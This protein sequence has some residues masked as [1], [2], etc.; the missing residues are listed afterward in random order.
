MINKKSSLII[1]ARIAK[2]EEERS[3]RGLDMFP[4]KSSKFLFFGSQNIETV[5]IYRVNKKKI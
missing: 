4:S 3:I 5:M 1:T 2:V